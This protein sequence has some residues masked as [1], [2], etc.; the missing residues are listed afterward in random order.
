MVVRLVDEVFVKI[1]G[2]KYYLWLAVDHGDEVLA[3]C[4]KKR[5]AELKTGVRPFDD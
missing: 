3:H 4:V 5:R 1:N 2:E